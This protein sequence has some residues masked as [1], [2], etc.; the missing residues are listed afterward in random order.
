VGDAPAAVS[1]SNNPEAH[2]FEAVVDGVTAFSQYHLRDGLI[3]FVH[4]VVPPAL[5]G[6]GVG[7]ALARAG[8]AYARE[9]GL[10]VV[11]T[12]KFIAGFIAKH[13]EYQDLL[14]A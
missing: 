3:I 9:Q 14:L 8:L 2:R 6:K 12:C 4:T 5:E 13:P 11:A 10:K 1:V 7:G